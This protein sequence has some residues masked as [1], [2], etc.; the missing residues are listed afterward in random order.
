MN[1][2][3]RL[4][5]PTPTIYLIDEQE[6]RIYMEYLGDH[7]LTI[8]EFIRQVGDLT[9]PVFNWLIDKIA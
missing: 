9:H 2:I 6:R 3:R 8:K 4:G 5:V 7:A 1:R